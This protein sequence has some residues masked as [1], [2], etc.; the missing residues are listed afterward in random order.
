[1]LAIAPALPTVAIDVYNAQDIDNRGQAAT[2]PWTLII[3]PQEREALDWIRHATP[4]DA[5]VQMEPQARYSGTWAYVPAFAERRM[6]AGLPGSM[7]P[8]RPY[9]LATD[10][11]MFGIFRASKVKD[12]WE[13]AHFLGIGYL[14]VGEPERERYQEAVELLASDPTL[15]HPAF[16]NEAITVYEVA[17]R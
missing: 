6:V 16:H 2:F 7:I 15:F 4:P 10:N 11:V 5:I 9:R 1:V 17:G 8:M 3:T 13:M 14:L 12:M